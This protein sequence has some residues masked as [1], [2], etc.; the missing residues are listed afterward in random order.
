MT[1]RSTSSEKHDVDVVAPEC[2]HQIGGQVRLVAIA[3]CRTQDMRIHVDRDVNI[4]V[5][6]RR[7]G[8]LRAEQ[9]CLENLRACAE[10]V[11]DAASERFAGCGIAY[12]YARF[13]LGLDHADR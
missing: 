9:V 4:A 8:R 5:R 3:T 13:G 6:P 11:A 2:G 7:A 1:C 10:R 12:S